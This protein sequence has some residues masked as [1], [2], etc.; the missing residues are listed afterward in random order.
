MLDILCIPLC[1]IMVYMQY[2]RKHVWFLYVKY[3]CHCCWYCICPNYLPTEM[4]A[5]SVFGKTIRREMSCLILARQTTH[6]SKQTETLHNSTYIKPKYT[7]QSN[8]SYPLSTQNIQIS[9]PKLILYK[10]GA[11]RNL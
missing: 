10:I 11:D 2:G 4:R 3:Y 8:P 7:P 5:H 6:K 1:I 9:H